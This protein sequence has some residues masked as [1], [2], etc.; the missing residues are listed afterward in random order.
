M[1]FGTVTKLKIVEDVR[2]GMHEDKCGGMFSSEQRIRASKERSFPMDHVYYTLLAD[3]CD[4]Q[5]GP[6][7]GACDGDCD[8]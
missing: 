3:G 1:K 4:G 2:S 6:G 5:C 8:G 7:G